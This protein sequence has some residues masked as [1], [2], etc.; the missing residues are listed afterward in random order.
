MRARTGLR[1][2][3]A[4][5]RPRPPRQ[6][7]TLLVYRNIAIDLVIPFETAACAMSHG[8]R[9]VGKCLIEAIGPI[10]ALRRGRLRD[11]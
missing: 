5:N 10:M 9:G 8:G 4:G 7:E 11:P 6:N 2:P 1:E 3:Q